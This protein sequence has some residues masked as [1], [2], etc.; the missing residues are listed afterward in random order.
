VG[1]V[2]LDLRGSLWALDVENVNVF[3]PVN[4]PAFRIFKEDPKQG[5]Q[6]L[7]LGEVSDVFPASDGRYYVSYWMHEGG[8]VVLDSNFQMQEKWFWNKRESD[9]R[10]AFWNSVEDNEGNIWMARQG[11][12]LHI[13]NIKKRRHRTLHCPEFMGTSPYRALKD[14]Q[15][16][17]WWGLWRSKGITKWDC[18][19]HKFTNYP[20]T[21]ADHALVYN[22]IEDGP[23]L[24]WLSTEVGIIKFDRK[25]GQ[26]L[27]N[28]PPPVT[29]SLHSLK[30][31][32][33]GLVKTSD[34]TLIGGCIAGI[35][36]F[37]LKTEQFRILR[38]KGI[39]SV[40]R[41][42][43]D[44][45]MDAKGYVY[46]GYPGG[47]VR[48]HPS[49][50]E[51]TI[52]PLAEL[53]GFP[54]QARF[55]PNP[56]PGGRRAFGAN[57]RFVVLDI[58]ALENAPPVTKPRVTLFAVDGDS[59]V[60]GRDIEK[61]IC[62][63]HNENYFTLYFSSF[64][65]PDVSLYYSYRLK[66]LKDEWR[67]PSPLASARFTNVPP[68][69]YL[70]EVRAQLVNG[71]PTEIASL[72]IKIHPPFWQTWW[73]RLLALVSLASIIRIVF[74]YRLRQQLEKEAIRQ[75]IAHDL[76]DEIGSTLSSI[77]ILSEAAMRQLQQDIDRA[78]FGTIGVRTRQV[79]D[80]ISDIVWSVNPG[81]DSMEN[82]LQRMRGFSIEVLEPQGITLHFHAD[83][84]AKAMNLSMELR[85]DFYLLFKEAVNNAAKYSQAGEVWV[86]VQNTTGKLHLEIR[87][88]GRGFDP[89]A[90]QRGNG[91]SNMQRR[92]ER[93]GGR[94]RIESAPEVGTRIWLEV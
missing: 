30:G 11:G 15:G 10:N 65:L 82:V 12:W 75:R 27:N 18:R 68:G 53:V 70:F 92:A 60:L 80:S 61:P 16:N 37:N 89:A 25:A 34:S 46:Y 90:V 76:H 50:L 32:V 56:L 8:V 59:S 94:L 31:V 69:T 23:N 64:N 41:S 42:T 49:K 35:F 84:A 58:A 77:S 91:L 81:N 52:I 86:S 43:S 45:V 5:A 40:P 29:D 13:Y 3:N 79:M 48:F 33:V 22:I 44:M 54:F 39:E 73:F 21:P 6:S 28:Y 83:E 87:D 26:C 19:T 24:L 14:S 85:K 51:L 55:F 62:L 74:L 17:L 88:N 93:L 1:W 36:E 57:D 4:K 2:H 38:F 67:Q 9:H 71:T 20:L 63:R 72:S 78:R 7:P 66:G 47:M